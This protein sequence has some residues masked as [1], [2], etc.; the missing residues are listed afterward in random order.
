VRRG[1]FMFL[2]VHACSPNRCGRVSNATIDRIIDRSFVAR[3]DG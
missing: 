2:F 1:R 3:M